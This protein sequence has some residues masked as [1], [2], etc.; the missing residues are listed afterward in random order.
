[1]NVIDPHA[2]GRP[3][4]DMPADMA[5]EVLG[6]ASLADD[7][8]TAFPLSPAQL[9][10][11][12]AIEESPGNPAFNLAF[13]WMAEGGLEPQM[14]DRAVQML[15]ERH[16]VLRARVLRIDEAPMQ[17]IAPAMTIAVPVID[18]EADGEAQMSRLC[19]EEARRSFDIGAGPLIR[20]SLLR[21]QADRHVLLL[22]V[23]HIIADGWSVGV[24]MRDLQALYAALVEK[25]VP[26]LAELPVQF[27]DY[28][29]WQQERI[30]ETGIDD[31]LAFWRKQLD[32]YLRLDVPSDH[33][34]P[35][36]RTSGGDIVSALMSSE[37]AEGLAALVRRDGGTIFSVT[38]AACMALLHRYTGVQDIALGSAHAGRDRAEI[39]GVVGLFVNPFLLR[40]TVH[41]TDSFAVLAAR[42][43]DRVWETVA[44]QEMPFELA[45][46][47]LR[48]E[49]REEDRPWRDPF[50]T[51]NFNCYR[52]YGGN[53]NLM[54]AFGGLHLTPIPSVSQ[55]A[56]YDLNFFLI[57]RDGRWRVS[58][59]Y[60]NGLYRPETAERLL[61]AFCALLDQVARNPDRRTADVALDLPG[62]AGE[63]ETQA[64][65][66]DADTGQVAADTMTPDGATIGQESA[67]DVFALPTSPA[68]QRFWLLTKVNPGGTAFNMPSTMRL[69]GPLSR[70]RLQQSFDLLIRRHEI[71][72]TT[73]RE[74]EGDLLQ[75][76]APAG[77]VPL[78]VSD[79]D[80]MPAESAEA[81]TQTILREEA[82][83]HFD[84]EQGPLI[85]AHL[86][87]RSDT[88]HVLLIVVHHILADG[89]SS[90]IVQRDLW[91]TYEALAEGRE[92]AL[93][94][95][96]IQYADFAAWQRD[97][98]GSDEAR[99]QLAFWMERLG[100][101]LPILDIPTDRAPTGRPAR[102]GAA[103]SVALPAGLVGDLKAFSK[104]ENAT[105]YMVLLASFSILLARY[106]G[107]DDVIIG[108]PVAKRRPETEPLI[109]PFAG[110]IALRFD[111]TGDPTLRQVIR[112]SVDIS[113]DA[114]ANADMSFEWLF[115]KLK[116]RTRRG[117]NP[118]FQ[119][120]FF[121]QVAFLQARTLRDLTVTPMPAI[122]VGTPFE[123]QLAVIERDEQL[124]ANLEYNPDLFDATT[125]RSILTDF[126]RI[127]QAIIATPDLPVG[128]LPPLSALRTGH[129]S[130]AEQPSEHRFVAP[131]T[132]DEAA[133]AQIWAKIMEV[134]NI[135]V[136]DDF[137]EIGGTSIMAARLVLMLEK[138]LGV[139]LDLSSI[140]VAP[141]VEQLTQKIRAARQ[142]EPSQVIPLRPSGSKVP[143]FCVH[144]GGGHVLHYRELTTLLD[145]DQPVYGLQA[146]DL[147]G[148]QRTTTV[149]QL[150][151]HY[152]ADVRRIQKHGPYQFCG[153]SFGGLVAY[154][155]ANQLVAAGEEVGLIAL[156]D[157]G[158]PAYYRN[159]PPERSVAFRSTYLRDRLRKY[160][161]N[162]MWGRISIAV[163][164]LRRLIGSRTSIAAWKMVR[165]LFQ[166]IGRPIPRIV[167]SNFIMFLLIGRGY[168]P[169]PYPGV[170]HLFR[171]EARTAEYL[172][173]V[174]LGWEQMAGKGVAVHYVA[175]GHV[176]M[177]EKPNVVPLVEELRGLLVGDIQSVRL[178]D[179]HR[180]PP[181]AAV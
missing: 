99:E 2:E 22:T 48:A 161:R 34:R 175:G 101:T 1:M 86:V 137:F 106:S 88:D 103:E 95:L 172:A 98:L 113:T 47:T 129:V 91:S 15:I 3:L 21:M 23:H 63:I 165:R 108:S 164:D 168:V 171:A 153:L 146:P 122:R 159:L 65:G 11:F 51:V 138:E 160:A 70:S 62:G 157:T 134:P 115:D 56:L 121:Y 41:D 130:V 44:H 50:F 53:A 37:T 177:M 181:T 87:R 147:D 92:P 73:F 102:R 80:G 27:A 78:A 155:M 52:A 94:P 169:K 17:L 66:E 4:D 74:V 83:K 26:A 24:M 151:A 118:L 100:G 145:A 90:N 110:P 142:S 54:P 152:L 97:W 79:L 139:R 144:G 8:V 31:S 13:R 135:G 163:H 14:F 132:A 131:R 140:L 43:R 33:P 112:Q 125:I 154:E 114:M 179:R 75:V 59:E 20:V 127:L 46:K 180:I 104:T 60:N 176:T 128:A 141:T 9:R 58:L 105:L 158:N 167:R 67:A 89:W 76:I 5:D 111:M 149:E 7:E 61:A 133:V 42:V 30:G 29:V 84:L 49:R 93:P 120:Y 36:E 126:E 45:I 109:G 69:Q 96:D 150:A 178:E 38:L 156:F 170:I 39:E 19:A 72:R 64:D 136:T 40:E 119:F 107:Q 174:A 12:E 117:R 28:V 25:R 148:A 68:Q 57:E 10:M 173:D 6:V 16:E 81:R 116:V 82:E 77:A 35:E 18:I 162:L 32:G 123:L 124:R 71:L 85:R 166:A 143:L 55:G